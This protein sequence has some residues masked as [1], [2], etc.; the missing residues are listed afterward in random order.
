MGTFRQELALAL[1][2]FSNAT[3]ISLAV[4]LS[5]FAGVLSG[6]YLDTKLFHG[7]TYPWLTIICFL[8]GLGGGIKNFIIL[9]KRFTKEA[10]K[11]EGERQGNSLGSNPESHNDKGGP[12]REP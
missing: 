10:E 7:R 1:R 12:H 6:Y 8:F 9:T 5:V 3:T 11:K 4:V 2:S